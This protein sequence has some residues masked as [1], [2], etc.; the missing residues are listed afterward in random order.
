MVCAIALAVV[1]VVVDGRRT[2]GH[3]PIRRALVG[4]ITV[5]I[6]AVLLVAKH[7]SYTTTL[8]NYYWNDHYLMPA[9]GLVGVMVGL[10]WILL[11]P[12]LLRARL[13]RTIV[14][15]ALVL[16]GLG[17][18]ATLRTVY[19]MLVRD[20]DLQ[21]EVTNYAQKNFP[22]AKIAYFY[23]ASSVPYALFFGD[24]GAGDHYQNK[25]ASVYPDALH[26]SIFAKA[27][28]TVG[29]GEN[30]TT[31]LFQGNP[32]MYRNYVAAQF[33]KKAKKLFG[34]EVEVLYEIEV[35]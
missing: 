8:Y 22:N 30:E 34:N 23:R 17:Q 33:P 35:R 24:S 7:P 5:Q 28:L 1:A 25:I 20:R 4:L 9:L 2:D 27:F 21:I 3:Q 31:L 14:L 10:V 6:A 19:G 32:A 12:L 16:F 18:G 15:I 13:G 26:Y 11:S 29:P